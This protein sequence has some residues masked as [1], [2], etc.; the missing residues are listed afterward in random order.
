MNIIRKEDLLIDSENN[1]RIN[2]EKEITYYKNGEKKSIEINGETYYT[3]S[4]GAKQIIPGMIRDAKTY[5][6]SVG[7][8]NNANELIAIAKL[9]KPI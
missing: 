6:T 7:L 5:I 4:S 1:I 8:Y 9:S 3:Q 2:P